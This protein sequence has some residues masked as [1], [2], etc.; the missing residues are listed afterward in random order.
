LALDSRPRAGP[1]EVARPRAERRAYRAVGDAMNVAARIE[2]ANKVYDAGARVRGDRRAGRRCLLAREIDRVPVVGRTKPIA[3]I[4]LLSPAGRPIRRSRPSRHAT[5]SVSQPTARATSLAPHA[6][7][8]LALAPDG[9]VPLA[10]SRLLA[11]SY[12]A[13]ATLLLIGSTAAVGG[14][15]SRA[16][17][18]SMSETTATVAA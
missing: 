16:R 1:D 7:S 6:R 12:R 10:R 8:C 3:L 9:A 5:P 2:V 4:E 18:G 11:F 13:C 14:D 17:H 15:S